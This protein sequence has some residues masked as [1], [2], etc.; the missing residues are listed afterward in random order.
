MAVEI[1]YFLG[2]MPQSGPGRS[3]MKQKA[4][5]GKKRPES[6]KSMKSEDRRPSSAPVPVED[7]AYEMQ[8]MIEQVLQLQVF[9]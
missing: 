8:Q 6:T 7:D 3:A 5:G 1:L 4:A 2:D 9:M